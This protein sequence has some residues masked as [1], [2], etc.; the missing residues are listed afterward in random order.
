MQTKAAEATIYDAIHKVMSFTPELS[1]LIRELID[2][3]VVQRLRGIKQMALADLVFPTATHSRFSHS[4]GCCHLALRILEQ[5]SKR[6][7]ISGEL[8]RYV[9]VAALLHDIGHGPFSHAFESYLRSELGFPVQHEGWTALF[10]ADPE[11]A[12]V[13]KRYEIDRELLLLLIT[14]K[15]EDRKAAF[16]SYSHIPHL[17]LGSDIIGSQLDADRLDYLLRDSHFCGVSYGSFD[18]GW[19]VNCLLPVQ[20]DDG[21]RLGITSKGLGGVENFLTSRRQMYQNIY[22]HPK[23]VAI[24]KLLI[25]L[26]QELQKLL[27]DS[28]ELQSMVSPPLQAFLT[29]LKDPIS[30]DN[31]R[32]AKYEAYHYLCDYDIWSMIRSLNQP[33]LQ[34][35]KR[36][37]TLRQLAHSFGRRRPPIMFRVSQAQRAEEELQK[38][39]TSLPCADWQLQLV[40][41][42][43]AMYSRNE[44]PILVADRRLGHLDF[45]FSNPQPLNQRSELVQQLSDRI[46]PQHYVMIDEHCYRQ[47]QESIL[48]LESRLSAD[49]SPA[50]KY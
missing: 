24:E 2:L 25:A 21:L 13:L 37:R 5:L 50:S 29:D 10:L 40:E 43:F 42:S 7:D 6:L 1:P 34:L 15:G 46:Q 27:P 32:S 23:L 45:N 14:K 20:T 16:Q 17:L 11:L 33:T 36:Y 4:I 38:L 12:E 35:S 44:D 19:L 8:R 30:P 41:V 39:K 31:F 47:H 3:P 18:L 9:A 49:N 28:D 22:Y 48:G 26:L